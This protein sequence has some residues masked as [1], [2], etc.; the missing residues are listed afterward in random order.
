MQALRD[1]DVIEFGEGDDRMTALV[2]LVA[3][4]AV[5]FDFCDGSMPRVAR[6]DELPAYRVFDPATF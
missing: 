2:L 3:P 6:A 1:G 4:E 5:I